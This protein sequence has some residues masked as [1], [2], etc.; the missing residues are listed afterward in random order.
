MGRGSADCSGNPNLLYGEVS[1]RRSGADPEREFFDLMMI[2]ELETQPP[3]SYRFD[4]GKAFA[5]SVTERSIK[6]LSR[7]NWE[8]TWLGSWLSE[9]RKQGDPVITE[10][11]DLADANG[12][13]WKCRLDAESAIAWCE[14]RGIKLG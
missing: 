4:V 10:Y 9:Q 8:G 12:D 2:I 1:P 5:A 6:E 14:R 11:L 3:I 7:T 13:W